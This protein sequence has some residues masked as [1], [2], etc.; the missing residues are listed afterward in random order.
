MFIIITQLSIVQH[1]HFDDLIK[2]ETQ[3][4]LQKQLIEAKICVIIFVRF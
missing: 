1:G 4:T 3:L 2:S